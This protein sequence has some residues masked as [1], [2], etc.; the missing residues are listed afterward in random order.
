[1]FGGDPAVTWGVMLNVVLQTGLVLLAL[2]NQWDA[3]RT[4]KAAF[5]VA[6]IALIVESIGTATGFPFGRITIPP[7]SSRRLAHVP[8]LIPLG[9]G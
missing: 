2:D 5:S 1:M 8:L 6:A 3:R 4:V 9:P 7:N